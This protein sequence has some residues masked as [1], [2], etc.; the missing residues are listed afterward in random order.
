MC[1]VIDQAG[2]TP[3]QSSGTQKAD[4]GRA[5]QINKQCPRVAPA[6]R[7]SRITRTRRASGR[8]R[9]RLERLPTGPML[10]LLLSWSCWAPVRFRPGLSASLV[11]R[12]G[13]HLSPGC[14]PSF[15]SLFPPFFE[16]F[17]FHNRRPSFA[18]LFSFTSICQNA[19]FSSSQSGFS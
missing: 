1:V 7:I 2:A 8:R 3:A 13:S 16:S 10:G 5:A 4:Q 6:Q 11:S 15:Y 17:L 19:R 14:G 9:E 18:F 12:T